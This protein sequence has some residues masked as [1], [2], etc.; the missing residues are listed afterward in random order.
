MRVRAFD[1]VSGSVDR[2]IFWIDSIEGLDA[3]KQRVDMIAADRPG[4]YFVFDV[5]ENLVLYS[6]DTTANEDA[7]NQKKFG[8]VTQLET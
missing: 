4:K 8:G 6:V 1:I 7:K 5:H 3:A 2:G